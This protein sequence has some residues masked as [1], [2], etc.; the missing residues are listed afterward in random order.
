[1]KSF[2]Q[3]LTEN[4]KRY[5]F[6]IKLACDC[7]KDCASKI[8]GA[9]AEFGVQSV[10]SGKSSPIQATHI[11]F[12]EHKNI[13]VTVFD[14]VTSYPTTS[15]QVL[16]KVAHLLNIPQGDVRVHNEHEQ[17]EIDLNHENDEPTGEAVVGTDY[18]KVNH[19]DLVGE[20]RK[21][22]LLKDLSKA[23]HLPEQYKGIND[24]LFP[25]A[26]KSKEQPEQSTVTE[27]QGMTSPVG[28]KKVKLTPY[29]DSVHNSLNVAAKAKGKVK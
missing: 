17:A 21:F 1:M 25:K 11:E 4:Q 27:K 16:S 10:S 3:Y 13:S 14:A 5:E 23:K 12:P 29:A 6:K 2:K 20:K 24:P 9:L 8:K 18:E 15:K 26:K 28:T 19:Q 7:P 22:S